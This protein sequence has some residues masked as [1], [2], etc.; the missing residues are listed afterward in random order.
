MVFAIHPR[1]RAMIASAEMD[2]VLDAPFGY[3]PNGYGTYLSD[4]VDYGYYKGLENANTPEALQKKI[5]ELARHPERDLLIPSP[6]AALCSTD[7]R[8]ERALITVLFFSPYLARVEHPSSVHEPLCEY[9]AGHYRLV[10]AGAP[11]NFE[12]ELWVPAGES[13]AGHHFD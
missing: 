6:S 12:Y 9:I 4:A 13:Q 8:L 2:G 7:V 11:E 3:K 1:T 10:R 5:D